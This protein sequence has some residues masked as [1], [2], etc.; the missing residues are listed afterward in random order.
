MRLSSVCGLDKKSNSNGL[1]F[2][3]LFLRHLKANRHAGR[4]DSHELGSPPDKS[5]IIALSISFRV[6]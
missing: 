4:C 1:Y 5:R 3:R 6:R 2:V